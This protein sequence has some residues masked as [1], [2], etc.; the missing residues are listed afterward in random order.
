MALSTTL[1]VR[2]LLSLEADNSSDSAAGW[3]SLKPANVVAAVS[4][5]TA[6]LSAEWLLLAQ[7]FR[8][9]GA[10]DLAGLLPL[11][12]SCSGVEPG[13]G[14]AATFL[15]EPCLGVAG[16]LGTALS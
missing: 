11:D 6:F 7:S 12:R 15:S 16:L 1:N 10:L 5:V 13:S 9:L 2:L 4:P 14:P 3:S 8:G